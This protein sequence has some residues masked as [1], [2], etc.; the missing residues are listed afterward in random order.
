MIETTVESEGAIAS[1]IMKGSATMTE[2]ATGSA[3]VIETE[4]VTAM[5][6][7]NETGSETGIEIIG[8]ATTPRIG[9]VATMVGTMGRAVAPAQRCL[10]SVGK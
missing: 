5:G 7:G 10:R 6:T 1:E 9:N 3:T 2:S 8:R 4:S